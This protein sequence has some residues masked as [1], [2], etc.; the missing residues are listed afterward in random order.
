MRNKILSL[1]IIFI[2]LF[3]VCSYAET[4]IK[5]EVNKVN[6]TLDDSLTYKVTVMSDQKR[7]P[8][9][10]IPK[11]E[12]FKVISEGQ[13]SNMSFSKGII[14]TG[15]SYEFIL[16]PLKAGKLNIPAAKIKVDK[17][18]Y[19]S[20]SFEL[21]VANGKIPPKSKPEEIPAQPDKHIPESSSPKIT[22]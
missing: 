16:K 22:L 14:K 4:S 6:L 19:S 12:G 7:L 15:L 18:V 2:F 11:F 13:S 21:D 1:S 3:L 10:E 8:V 17:E 9:P 5:A 20:Q